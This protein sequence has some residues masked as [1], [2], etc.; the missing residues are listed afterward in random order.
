MTGFEPAT[1]LGPR[2]FQKRVVLVG[3]TDNLIKGKIGR[4]MS[5]LRPEAEKKEARRRSARRQ[6][7][8]ACSRRLGDHVEAKGDV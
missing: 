1:E 7:K 6:K 3:L 2:R 5:Q 8:K 4:A